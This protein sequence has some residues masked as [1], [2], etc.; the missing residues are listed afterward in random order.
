MLRFPTWFHEGEKLSIQQKFVDVPTWLRHL[1]RLTSQ[2]AR[3]CMNSVRCWVTRRLEVRLNQP[4]LV[5]LR[6]TICWNNYVPASSTMN[7]NAH[8]TLLTIFILLPL[9]TALEHHTYS[10]LHASRSPAIVF[11]MNHVTS[12][13]SFCVRSSVALKRI[14]IYCRGATTSVWRC[15]PSIPS[16]AQLVHRSFSPS[17]CSLREW[18]LT[19]GNLGIACAMSVAGLFSNCRVRLLRRPCV[20]AKGGAL[21]FVTHR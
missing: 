2:N 10:Y 1:H 6:S 18:I 13:A 20:A 5:L 16:S 3:Q 8:W 4:C 14:R 12:Q 21:E 9:L 15:S 17:L 11:T 19:T 7:H